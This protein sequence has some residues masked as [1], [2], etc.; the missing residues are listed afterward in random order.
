M[1]SNGPVIVAIDDYPDNLVAVKAFVTDAFPGAR[2]FTAENGRDG[3]ELV[4][5]TNPDVILLDIV[6]PEMDGFEVCRFLKQDPQF[7]HIPVIFLTALRD[8]RESRI[9]AL[10]AG[11]EAFISKPFEEAEFIA[12]IRAMV[13]IKAANERDLKEK[14]TLADLVTERTA[15]LERELAKRVKAEQELISANQILTQNRA[16]ML[17]LLEELKEEVNARKKGEN[18]FKTV[19]T[20]LNGIVFSVDTSG[21]FTLSEG[22]GLSSLNLVSGQVVGQSVFEI[23]RDVP[24]IVAGMKAALAG[25]PWSGIVFIQGTVFD[26]YVSPVFDI[27]KNVEG[28][29]GI[30]TDITERELIKDAIEQE[31]KFSDLIFD[32]PQ[33]TIFLFEPATGKPLRWN[34]RFTEVSGYTDDEIAGMKAPDDFYDEDDRIRAK[35]YLARNLAENITVELSLITKQ[36]VHIPFDYSATPLKATDGRELLLSIGRNITERKRAERELLTV[37]GRLKEAQK[38]AHIGSW[39][40]DA[41]NDITIWSE[42]L[43]RISGRD[44]SLPALSYGDIHHMFTPASWIRFSD[45][46]TLA[47]STGDPFN[48]ELEVVRPD[49]NI[50]W[51][52]AFGTAKRDDNGEI[53]GLFGTLQDIH[54]RK[55]DEAFLTSANRDLTIEKEKAQRYFDIAGS[56]L[57][58]LDRN[59]VVTLI[60]QKGCEILGHRKDE[61]IGKNWFTTFLPERLIDQVRGVFA[62]IIAGNIEFVE[63]Y[64]NPVVRGDGEERILAWHNSILTDEQGHITGILSAA[65][66]ITEHNR[67]LSELALN[68]EQLSAAYDELSKSQ[69]QLKYQ[70]NALTSSEENLRQTKE[71]LENLISV[72]NVPIIIWD[73]SFQITRINRAFETL[74]GRPADEIVGTSFETLFPLHESDRAN[75][76]IQATREGV[77]WQTTEIGI[78]HQDGSLHTI[79]WNSSTLFSPDGIT[80][81]ATIAQGQDI[82]DQRRLEKEKE[83]AIAQIQKNLAQLALLNDGIRN[84]LMVIGMSTDMVDNQQVTDIIHDEI[85]QIDQMINQVDQRWVE[86]EKILNYL[87]KHHQVEISQSSDPDTTNDTGFVKPR[88]IMPLV[89]EVQAELYTILDSIDAL[90]YVADM[91]TYELLFINRFGRRLFGNTIGKKCYETIQN[92]MDRPCSFC[93]NHLLT[94]HSGPTGVYQWEYQ[95]TRNGRWYDCR[96]RAIRWSDGRL[97]HLHIAT[98]ITE[99]KQAQD[100]LRSSEASLQSLIKTIPDL[101]WL[102]DRD[103]I[104]LS[105]NPMFERFFGAREADI[106]G[107]TDYDFVDQKLADFFRKHDL[108]ALEAGKPSINEEWVTFADDGH[109]ALL[110]TIKKPMYDS[111]GDLIGV[112]GIGRDIT[113]RYRHELTLRESEERF[114]GLFNTITSGVAIYEVRNDGASGKDYIIKSFNKSALTIEGKTIEEVVGKSLFDLRPTIDEYGLIPVFQEVWKTGIPGFFPQTIYLDENYSSWYE[115]RVFRLA[116]GEIVAVYDDV[117]ER[118]QGELEFISAH[119]RMKEAQRLAHIG[120]WDWMVKTDTITWSEELYRIK[121]RDPHEPTPSYTELSHYYTPESW[122]ELQDAVTHALSTGESYELELQ[123]IRPDGT[124]AWIRAFGEPVYSPAGEI[125]GLHGTVQDITKQKESE[126]KITL[127]ATRLEAL[128]TLNKN[129]DAPPD[130]IFDYAIEASL[131]ITGS[132]H[133]FFGLIDPREQM[134]TIHSWSKEAMAGCEIPQKPIRYPIESAGIWGDTVRK[135]KPTIINDYAS[136]PSRKGCPKG[137]IPITRFLG[138]PIHDGERI[139]AIIAVANKS[140]DYLDDDIHA[141]TAFGY[142]VWRIIERK[143]TLE[144]IYLKNFA[145]ESSMNGIAIADLSGNL[146]YINPAF[147]KIWNYPDEIEVLGRSAVSFWKNP[148]SAL[149]VISVLKEKGYWTGEMEAA[150]AGGNVATLHVSAHF[151]KDSAGKPLALMALFIDITDLN[152]SEHAL[153]QANRQLN[154]LS[155]ITRHDMLN[156]VNA[157]H[158]LVEQV[159]MK[160]DSSCATREFENLETTISDI[161][162]Q[163]GFTRVYQ[164]LGSNTPQWIPL[165]EILSAV[166]F[167]H[168]IRRINNSI[169]IEIFA[170]PLIRK[171]FENLLDNSIRHGKNTSIIAISCEQKNNDMVLIYEDDGQGIP[172]EEKELIFE[173]GYGKNTGFGLFFVREILSITG[174]TISESGQEGIG[175]RFEISLPEGVWR[176][177]NEDTG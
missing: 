164:D 141:L 33:D 92:E 118:K 147:L 101:I 75:R 95:N 115:N 93:T 42:E 16:E 133:S 56:L 120:T 173:R 94:D 80:P 167:P 170:D 66:D 31:K 139:V 52:N 63:Y 136:Y 53:T 45:A 109:I 76:L 68:N 86:S 1:D 67:L 29:A 174:I 15:Q 123:I 122:Q 176:L 40:W 70:F 149:E 91:D 135:R 171:L 8:D 36:G 107:K 25:K 28:A 119:Q 168:T 10:E 3:I 47:L 148:E 59:G 158:L 121:G 130:T 41:E 102:K 71:Y 37:Q 21:T 138:V 83:K 111:R 134:M 142:E 165:Y 35:E 113:E 105:C 128:L 112:L 44:S 104:Y 131:K 172:T 24:D 169:D 163:I 39:D 175:V 100:A 84:P 127:H 117:T 166:H 140:V 57:L 14:E 61:I 79:L 146:T 98:D 114:R 81:V 38:I 7:Q 88:L 26:V 58:T 43:Y 20:N 12:Q 89:E 103:G 159:K 13:K 96:D 82:T 143:K 34:K 77:R 73:P 153:K 60:N 55:R 54:D 4:R 6:M 51:T 116:S 157:M 154:L 162:S 106:V 126:E 65:E 46:V 18:L 69:D 144:S 9:R 30:A 50:R 87:R 160:I 19:L 125:A 90:V 151:I 132:N 22:K 137:H 85:L 97:V 145:L 108:I 78:M 99:Y 72:A 32:A 64:E 2:V 62:E 48:L 177:H 150:I 161:Q 49:G 23:Y 129:A 5:D 155:G 124:R 11:G 27:H 156:T 152:R 74:I 17:N 110:E